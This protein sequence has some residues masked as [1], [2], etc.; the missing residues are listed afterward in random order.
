[1]IQERILELVK[2]GLTTGLVDPADEVYSVNR[3]LEVLGVDDIEDETF[4]KIEAQPAWTQEEAEEKLEGILEDMMTYAYDNGIMKENSI[5]YKDLFDTKLMGCLVNAPSVIRARFKDLY[6]NES[7]LAATDYF[8]KLSC[9]SNY[10]RRQR[11]KKDRKWTTDTEF[12]TLD[13]T[14]NLSKP[15]KDPKAIA[16]AKV[17][18]ANIDEYLGFLIQIH[19]ILF[20]ISRE[21]HDFYRSD[22]IFQCNKRHHFIC[23]GI[24]AR[25]IRN[26]TSDNLF[27]AVM[28]LR[29]SGF[30][31]QLEIQRR[32]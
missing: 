22:Q 15:E 24:L 11:I 6:D 5:V 9:D 30:I 19:L 1:M 25:L 23:L 3:L 32:P 14:I 18:A 7:S 20:K 31:I 28:H 21:D 26:H 10:I 4:E 29:S 8:Y 13:I 17:V 16:A 12:G 2:Y 27:C